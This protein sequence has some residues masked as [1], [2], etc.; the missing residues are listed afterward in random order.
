MACIL[1]R[2][3]GCRE[4]NEYL[5]GYNNNDRYFKVLDALCG[6]YLIAWHEANVAF[7][8]LFYEILLSIK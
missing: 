2:C 8:C 3:I 7:C 1:H 5:S 6:Y 4:R